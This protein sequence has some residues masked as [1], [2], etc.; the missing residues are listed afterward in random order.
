MAARVASEFAHIRDWVFDLDNC[1]YPAAAGLFALI[2]ERMG[3]YIQRLLDCDPAE[4]RRVQ[5]LFLDGKQRD[6]AAAVPDGLVDDVSLVGPR[7]RIR[8]RLDAWRESGVTTLLVA[9]RDPDSVRTI[10]ELAA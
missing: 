10:A 7:E 8:D 4:A 2:D 5:E 3:A 1:L 9:S 6:A